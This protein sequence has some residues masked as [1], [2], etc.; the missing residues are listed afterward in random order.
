MSYGIHTRI[1]DKFAITRTAGAI[2][3]KFVRTSMSL[4]TYRIRTDNDLVFIVVDAPMSVPTES[5]A[6]LMSEPQVD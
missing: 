3:S 6:E 4:M 1:H 2:R 5:W